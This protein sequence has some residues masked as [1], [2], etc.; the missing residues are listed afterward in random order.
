MNYLRLFF[1]FFCACLLTGCSYFGH[2][3]DY[4]RNVNDEPL[5]QQI[6]GKYFITKV[7]TYASH[8][9]SSQLQVEPY[10]AIQGIYRPEGGFD[11]KPV[12]YKYLVKEG[13]SFKITELNVNSSHLRKASSSDRVA[14]FIA[15]F[16]PSDHEPFTG[17]VTYLFAWP[18]ESLKPN[19]K[20]IDSI[21]IDEESIF[22]N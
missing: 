8:R 14:S 17:N 12:P 11:Y 4:K 21:E 19:L 5:G 9:G 7:E 2:L 3:A 20:Y 16:Y 6:V 18:S 13:T 22:Q 1:G 10:I 15:E